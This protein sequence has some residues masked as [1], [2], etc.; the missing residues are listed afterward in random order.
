M[1]FG[2]SSSI[3]AGLKGFAG[4]TQYSARV[5]TGMLLI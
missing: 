2:L 1:D 5:N 3:H 4:T